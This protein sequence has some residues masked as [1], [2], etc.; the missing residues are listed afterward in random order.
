MNLVGHLQD[1]R[2]RGTGRTRKMLVDAIYLAKKDG[3]TVEVACADKNHAMFLEKEILG[4]LKEST[5]EGKKIAGQRGVVIEPGVV[6][7]T[8]PPKDVII[9]PYALPKVLAD[10]AFLVDHYTLEC[11]WGD[12]INLWLHLSEMPE[13]TR[14]LDMLITTAG[15][16]PE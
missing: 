7:F 1:H 3:L 16:K 11:H 6:L 5:L 4:I 15:S 10:H 2:A 9:D 13:R 14:N 8:T 12:I